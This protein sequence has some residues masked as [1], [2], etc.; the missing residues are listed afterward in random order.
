MLENG[1]LDL[2]VIMGDQDFGADAWQRVIA[3]QC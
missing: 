1:S 3:K 2:D